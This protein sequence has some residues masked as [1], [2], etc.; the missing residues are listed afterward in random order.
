ME[1][2]CAWL[3]KTLSDGQPSSLLAVYERHRSRDDSLDLA[4]LLTF[5]PE[6]SQPEVASLLQEAISK[7]IF[8][9]EPNPG[10]GKENDGQR[11]AALKAGVD[12]TWLLVQN[13][14]TPPNSSL[15]ELIIYLHDALLSSMAV[16]VQNQISKI[17]EW[18]W[19]V[20][21][22]KRDDVVPRTILYLLMRS[23]GEESRIREPFSQP[24]RKVGTAADVRR[25]YTM[26]KALNALNLSSN[27]A[28][29]ESLRNLLLRCTTSAVYLRIDEGRK[30]LA[31][32]LTME[33]IQNEVFE[34]LINQ[35]A[36]IKKS[37]AQLFG[38]VFLIAWKIQRSDWLAEKLTKVSEFA[39]CAGAEPYASNLRIVLSAFHANKRVN[40]VDLL[41]NRVYGPVLYR[42]L[43]VASP[44]VRR[45]AV[46]ILADAFPIHDPGDLREA[47]ANSI[48]LQCSKLLELL[49]DPSPIVRKATVEGTCK[50][51]GLFWDLVPLGSAKRMIDIMTSKLAFDASAAQVRL[52]VFEGLDFMINNHLALELLSK[53][54]SK[55]K[56]LIHDRVERVRLSFLDLLISIKGKRLKGMR[57]FDIVPVEDLLLRLPRESAPAAT[58]IMTLI[59]TSYF[60]LEK[61]RRTMEEV[62]QSRTRACLSM[63]GTSREAASYFYK[64]VNLHVPPG[65][66]CEFVM[67]I[68]ESAIE[69]PDDPMQGK[70]ARKR[71]DK[72]MRQKRKSRK[73]LVN[74]ENNPPR[75]E[76][77]LLK[78][79]EKESAVQPNRDVTSR[80]TLFGVVAN[81]LTAIFPSLQKEK[82]KA[83][84]AY[85][86]RVFGG[87]ALKPMLIENENSIRLRATIWKVAGCISPSKMR[88]IINLWRE[89]IDSVMDLPR[90]NQ[91]EVSNFHELLGALMAC[92][93]R[94]NLL[95]T[96]SAVVCGWSDGAISGCR[97]STIGTKAQKKARGPR[98]GGIPSGGRTQSTS[99]NQLKTRT[100]ALV[101][102]RAC[103]NVLLNNEDFRELFLASIALNSSNP[104]GLQWSQ[105]VTALRKGALGALDFFLESDNDDRE[106]E[107]MPSFELLLG[108]LADTWRAA[109]LLVKFLRQDERACSELREMLVW[110]SGDEV[111]RRAF[112][113]DESFGIAAISVCLGFS[114]DVVALGYAS[115]SDLLCIE[116]LAQNIMH[117]RDFSEAVLTR[118]VLDILRM[119]FTLREQYV[120]DCEGGRVAALQCPPKSL[121]NSANVL[122]RSACDVL[123][124]CQADDDRPPGVPAKQTVLEKFMSDAMIGMQQEGDVFD[125]QQVF[126]KYF[127]TA[128][129]DS[130]KAERNLFASMLCNIVVSL[131]TSS[132]ECG[133]R[134]SFKL[135]SAIVSGMRFGAMGHASDRAVASVSC[136]LANSMFQFYTNCGE[137]RREPSAGARELFAKMQDTLCRQ[138]PESEETSD[139]CQDLP[140]EVNEVNKTLIALRNLTEK[141]ADGGE[142]DKST[143]GVRLDF[144][145]LEDD[146][147]TK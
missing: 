58:K 97:T 89:Q 24:S 62:A 87:E 76:N 60:P 136:F 1:K 94:W 107:Q 120:L 126:T 31:H 113:A 124:K 26:R 83:L 16:Q 13:R 23:F 102:L 46:I 54:L 99:R 3:L 42:N 71:G 19:S 146:A 72:R 145:R 140:E 105:L 137:T 33:D 38:V 90:E 74:D 82:N 4:D 131:A 35:L 139:G 128:F 141:D 95:P 78:E 22:K 138:F 53:A 10:D 86:D 63:L 103:S 7:V 11:T 57:Y 2:S 84:R 106:K 115:E 122:L 65:P 79:E 70:G 111:W 41:L 69:A 47:I 50:V 101:A 64:H 104:T 142:V 34:A 56:N 110:C 121:R 68:A 91:E 92:G 5:L 85:L 116:K 61:Q 49:E 36:S 132:A 48:N 27:A 100:N 67:S 14:K 129:E 147:N 66:L 127:L 39:V 45:N 133:P 144:D 21:D 130:D 20:A 93:I 43:M 51:L 73:R 25:V 59:V 123:I 32:L 18:M 12:M 29:S 135:Y 119:S 77:I 75:D 125:F 143:G 40:G 112:L 109:L 28:H 80:P 96:L 15:R 108:S 9:E 114:A 30:V 17:C 37:R 98:K 55:L 88:T 118:P 117:A 6:K 81:V 8:A 44:I 52:A 134:D